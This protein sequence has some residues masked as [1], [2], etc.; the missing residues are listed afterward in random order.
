MNLNRVFPLFSVGEGEGTVRRKVGYLQSAE[1][2]SAAA[3]ALLLMPL[4]LLDV[5]SLECFE[6]S[7]PPTTPAT[8]AVYEGN[9]KISIKSPR[10][11][12]LEYGRRQ[13]GNP[14]ERKQVEALQMITRAQL[15]NNK[16]YRNTDLDPR[17]FVPGL[18]GRFEALHVRRISRSATVLGRTVE[19]VHR[20]VIRSRA[21]IIRSR[22]IVR[23]LE[24]RLMYAYDFA[25]LECG[26]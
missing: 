9:P 10:I 24:S 2:A 19:V 12:L 20:I 26:K 7:T 1:E 23:H 8:M 17:C 13:A 16:K 11:Q 6:P 25:C 4:L 14:E 3:A 18:R 15:T 22:V 21:G 5:L